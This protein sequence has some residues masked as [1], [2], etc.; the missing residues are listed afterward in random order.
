MLTKWQKLAQTALLVL[1]PMQAVAQDR[2]LVRV[3]SQSIGAV[4]GRHGLKVLRS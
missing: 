1:L 4:A 3:P 2:W